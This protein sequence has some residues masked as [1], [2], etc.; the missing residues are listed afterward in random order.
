[1]TH[2]DIVNT[3]LARI[4]DDLDNP[5]LR[6]FVA[7][8]EKIGIGADSVTSDELFV[9]GFRMFRTALESTGEVSEGNQLIGVKQAGITVTI[10]SE[11]NK[12]GTWLVLKDESG[13]AGTSAITVDAETGTIDGS[14]TTQISSNYGKVSLYCDGDNWFSI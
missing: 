6:R 11:L 1:M 9:R 14:A 5:A 3:S 7:R 12:E 13:A 2:P 10:A 8:F 4:A